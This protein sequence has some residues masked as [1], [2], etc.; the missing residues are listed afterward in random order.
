MQLAEAALQVVAEDDAIASHSTVPF[1]VQPYLDRI[2][3]LTD[4]F[5]RQR[6]RPMIVKA[7]GA[8]AGAAAVAGQGPSCSPSPEAVLA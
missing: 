3:K 5:C 4:E 6:L 2:Q 7:V 8:D 1:P